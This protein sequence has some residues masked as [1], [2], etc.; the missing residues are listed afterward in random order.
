MTAVDSI[1][2]SAMEE[3]ILDVELM[4][5]P[6]PGEG[7]GED[8][9][10][11]GELD[12]GAKGLV[13]VDSGALGEAPKDPTSLVAV[14]GAV[15]GQLVAK[16][17]LAGDHVGVWSTRHQVPGVVDQQGHVLLLHSTTPVWVSEGGAN[18]ED[19]GGIQRSG[20]ISGQNQPIDGAKNIGDAPSHHQVDVPGVEVDG[21]RVI[22]RQLR[23][24][25]QDVGC[26]ERGRLASVVDDDGVDKASRA[27]RQGHV[28]HGRSRWGRAWRKRGRR[29]YVWR[30]RGRWG[31]AWRWH[32]RQGRTWRGKR[33]EWRR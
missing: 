22:H 9:V 13:V 15:R 25:R 10:N 14:E 12:D 19:R 21:D 24:G 23:A 1:R 3:G 28:W 27:R 8:G 11:S 17:S 7:E 6:I 5:R 16:E 29:G 26:H 30:R 33:R 32:G 2:Q 4:D 18:G 20:V 31:R